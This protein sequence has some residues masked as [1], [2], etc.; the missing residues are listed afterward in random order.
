PDSSSVHDVIV[1]H[2]MWSHSA[3]A[4][5]L[6]N[7]VAERGYRVHPLNLPAHDPTAKE[8][9]RDVAT[10]SLGV[11]RDAVL[12]Y[13][14]ELSPKGQVTLIGHSMGGL[15]AQMVAANYPIDH[16][17]LL[18][19]AGPAGINHI[20]P[21]SLLS[22][23]H[24]FRRL[25]FWK[26][27][28]KPSYEQARDGLLN[29]LD[30]PTAR[31]VYR[32]LIA[33]S[34]RAFAEIVLWFLDKGRA[35]ALPRH[36][37]GTKLIITAGQDRIVTASVG[38]AL[39]ARYPD[40]TVLEYPDNGHWLFHE[41]GSNRIF[42]DIADW[43]ESVAELDRHVLAHHEQPKSKSLQRPRPPQRRSSAAR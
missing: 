4:A 2:G 34:G 3:V 1:I 19:S 18:N 37:P 10:V 36:I 24:V 42:Q 39:A 38:E 16:L 32:G 5:P 43:L 12:Q 17:V 33:E 13:L 11:Y 20:S 31:K 8:Q 21:S 35:S 29:A 7:V 23:R 14:D 40:A 25:R 26:H 27:A 15:I 22:A 6:C 9:A 41:P 30:E 28:H